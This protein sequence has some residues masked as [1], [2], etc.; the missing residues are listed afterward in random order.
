MV[1]QCCYFFFKAVAGISSNKE[2]PKGLLS[3]DLKS[4]VVKLHLKTTQTKKHI[5][6]M[7]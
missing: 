4:L 2:M 5:L 6:T 7:H 1:N 3:L